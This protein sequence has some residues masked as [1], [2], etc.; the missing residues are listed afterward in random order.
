M[1][2]GLPL[3]LTGL[4]VTLLNGSGEVTIS[5]HHQQAH[6]GLGSARNHVLDEIAMTRGINDG[7]VPLSR[8][9]LLGGAGN[10]H[11]TLTLLLSAVHVESEGERRLAQGRGLLLQLLQLTLRDTAELEQQATSGRRLTG[12]D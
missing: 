7:V 4:V 6:I 10:G 12:V 2:A 5:R 8:E 3:D 11:T 9:E 1:L